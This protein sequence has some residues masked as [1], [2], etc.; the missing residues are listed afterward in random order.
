M[1]TLSRIRPHGKESRA[2]GH[3]DERRV[4]DGGT[5][6][7][8]GG[9]GDERIEGMEGY[10]SINFSHDEISVHELEICP[11]HHPKVQIYIFPYS[12]PSLVEGNS[13][14]K[15]PYFPFS[16]IKLAPPYVLGLGFDSCFGVC[17]PLSCQGSLRCIYSTL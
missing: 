12:Y 16:I 15:Q 2:S 13:A 5:K 3:C 7:E 8:G 4:E 10:Q 17:S 1:V 9:G 11:K 14:K 6:T